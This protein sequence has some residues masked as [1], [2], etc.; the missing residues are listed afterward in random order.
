M[1][2][3]HPVMKPFPVL[4]AVLPAVLIPLAAAAAP[5]AAPAKFAPAKFALTKPAPTPTAPAP[6]TPAPTTPAPSLAVASL[7][8]APAS[9][10]APFVPA[11]RNPTMGAGANLLEAAT[12]Q[13]DAL[14]R[15][16]ASSFG[17]LSDLTKVVQWARHLLANPWRR[18]RAGDV[19]A[20]L[21][22][23]IAMASLAGFV[24]RRKTERLLRH[25]ARMAPLAED[26]DDTPDPME[27]AE[28]GESE[29]MPQRH[30]LSHLLRL[31]PFAL[32]RFLLDL[33][34]VGAFLGVGYLILG[35]VLGATHVTR[36][37]GL[38]V[39]GVM[40]AGRVG[41]CVMRL[42][43]SPGEPRLRLLA[44]SDQ[45]A[46]ELTRWTNLILL[47]MVA[48]VGFTAFARLFGLPYE[49]VS[50]LQKLI[51]L[52]VHLMLIAAVLRARRPV[53]QWLRGGRAVHGLTAP[54]R[55]WLAAI[56][57]PVAIIW[58]AAMWLVR[59][60]AQQEG[61]LPLLR[62]AALSVLVLIAARLLYILGLGSLERAIRVAPEWDNRLPGICGR[63]R[64]YAAA[65]R[66]VFRLM[67]AV[68]G[69]LLLLHIWGWD[70]GHFLLASS[71][72]RP[73]LAIACNILAVL[74][75]GA[76]SWE[77]CNLWLYQHL[78][79]LEAMGADSRAIRL[80]TVMPIARTASLV[81][82]L[83][84]V[85]LVVLSQ[86]GINVGPLLAG[87]GIAGIAIGFG[88]QKLVQDVITGLFLL[89][90]NAIQVG[91]SVTAAGLT[92]TVEHLTL[93]S[94]QLRGFDGALHFIPFS[95]VTWVSNFNR[96]KALAS[97]RFEF[98][99]QTDLDQITALLTRAGE[100]L[101]QN[102]AI[103]PLLLGALSINGLEDIT[104]DKLVVSASL[105]CLPAGKDKVAYEFRSLL[106]GDLRAAGI[107]LA[108]SPPPVQFLAAPLQDAAAHGA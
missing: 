37:A 6:A 69:L 101:Q 104:G 11:P 19:L 62:D 13:I 45:G 3:R 78:V 12:I 53:A 87:A 61:L 60:I 49:A 42:I 33:L 40:A 82:L 106:L 98:P 52:A 38:A 99:A 76:L 66:L 97:W 108:G 4:L 47:V 51:A 63:L 71:W 70:G 54:L 90:D 84:V 32:A 80:R 67:L 93:R 94:L 91:D 24:V 8:K 1:I 50:A 73:L 107:E 75:L 100:A 59:D 58:I 35:T 102:Q 92:G 5:T 21:A 31:I 20:K 68:A 105:P 14:S 43:V 15:R 55:N 95:A 88:S 26:R 83:V 16:F 46:V 56:W 29:S 77:L 39:M 22:G 23:L 103:A 85:G 57:V 34:P 81:V 18:G 48:G 2:F 36:P 86:I 64:H 72:A 25:L 41:W 79:R 30:L 10:S 74:A 44:V 7:T 89:L 17:S 65:I 9:S 96:G 28:A 27:A